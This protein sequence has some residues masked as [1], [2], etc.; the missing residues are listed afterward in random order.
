MFGQKL[1]EL[2]KQK[3]LTQADMAKILG[4]ARTTYSSY[5]QGRRTPDVELQNKIADF[6]GVTLDY[7]HGRE[8]KEESELSSNQMTVAAHIDDDVSDEEMKEILSFIDYIKNR[9]HSK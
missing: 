8:A 9:D 4:V 5:E 3:K 7:L 1:I 6:F 2:R